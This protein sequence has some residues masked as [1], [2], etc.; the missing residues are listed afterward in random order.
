MTGKIQLSLV[1]G[2]P[3]SGELK[4]NL[5]SFNVSLE[6]INIIEEKNDV[7]L[8]VLKFKTIQEQSPVTHIFAESK[9]GAIS[10]S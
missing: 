7:I 9:T 1:A 10:V 5:G 4:S 6:G 3:V 2:T 8:K